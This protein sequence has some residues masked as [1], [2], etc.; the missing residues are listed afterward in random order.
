[1]GRILQAHAFE[2][3]GEPRALQTLCDIGPNFTSCYVSPALSFLTILGTFIW[4]VL[5]VV[6]K[7]KQVREENLRIKKL[8]SEK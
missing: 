2:S 5:H 1:M 4:I 8:Q 6:H 3:G 7:L